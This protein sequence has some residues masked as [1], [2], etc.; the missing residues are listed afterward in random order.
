MYDGG[1]ILLYSLS[2]WRETP[3]TTFKKCFDEI[4]RRHVVASIREEQE[5]AVYY[6]WRALRL[7]SS[8]GHVDVRFEAQDI[9]IFVAPPALAALPGF[10][11][12]RAVLC[13]ARSPG[14]SGDLRRAAALEGAVTTTHSQ[15][16][17]SPYAPTRVEVNADSDE[18]IRATAERM[19]IPYLAQP[20]AR[21]M[22]QIAASL[23]EYCRTLS[24]STDEDLNWHREDF[25]VRSLRFQPAGA[26]PPNAR[27]SRYQDP[28]T[29]IWRYRLW[30]GGQFGELDPDWGR[31]AILSACSKRILQYDQAKRDVLVP[32]G[33]PLP[34]LLARALGLCSGYAPNTGQRSGGR[35][36]GVPFRYEIFR[37]VP[38][39]IFRMVADK[40]GQQHQEQ[41]REWTL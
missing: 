39:S 41:E 2:A 40:A 17:L 9:T 3:W 23:E 14:T 16:L 11:I 6:R 27:L 29:T 19:G 20:P 10:G 21:T 38:P 36:Q 18:R 37:D 32:L 35:G 4:H 33:T 26:T 7:L 28:A 31:Y 5:T 15:T 1:D 8:L 13:G 25:N 12:R 22:A 24:W 30:R 34:T